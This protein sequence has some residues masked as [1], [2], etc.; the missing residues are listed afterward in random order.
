[1]TTALQ[2][3]AATGMIMVEKHGSDHK[4]RHEAV[5]GEPRSRKKQYKIRDG[6]PQG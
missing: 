6:G 3:L 4:D 1:M 5:S 2:R